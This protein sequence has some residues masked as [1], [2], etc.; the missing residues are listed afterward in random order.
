VSTDEIYPSLLSP[1]LTSIPSHEEA[2]ILSGTS[3]IESDNPTPP[4]NSVADST[5]PQR[6]MGVPPKGS[7]NTNKWK[8][9]LKWKQA[10]NWVIVQYS[11]EE[12][13]A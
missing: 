3:G 2:A 10:N 1:S 9:K 6:N 13:K 7:S 5:I 12:E 4:S 8:N 11:K